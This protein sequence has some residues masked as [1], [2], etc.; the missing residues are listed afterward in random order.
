VLTP[1]ALAAFTFLWRLGTSSLFTDESASWLAAD[2]PLASVFSRVRHAEVTPPGYFVGLHFWLALTG[3]DSEWSMRLLSVLA[4]IALVGATLWLGWLLAGRYAGLLAATFVG[5][6]PLAVQYAQEV[7]GYVF[8]MLFATLA[9]AAAVEARRSARHAERW[10]AAATLASVAAIWTH[11]TCLLVIAPLAIYIWRLPALSRR[12]RGAYL[13]VCSLVLAAVAPLM[14]EQ[15]RSGHYDGVAPF[16]GLNATNIEKV[17]GT[18]FDGRYGGHP[19]VYVAGAAAIVPALVYF[20]R[21]QPLNAERRIVLAAAVLPVSAV[22]LL[23]IAAVLTGEQTY[24]V[25]VTRY[26]AVGAPFMLIALAAAIVALA[27]SRRRG[28]VAR[29]A[30]AALVVL[31]AFASVSGLLATYASSWPDLRGAFA[32]ITGHYRAGDAV[33]VAD[34]QSRGNAHYGDADYY[35]ARL[36]QSHPGAEVTAEVGAYSAPAGAGRIWVESDTGALAAV[37]TALTAGGWHQ[38]WSG[39]FAPA[40]AAALEAR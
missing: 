17:L 25:L 37:A 3:S 14:I 19:L 16:A 35:V 38:S 8:A 32:Y 36:L 21:A 9:V 13:A 28:P 10:L 29:C 5:A 23:T 34:T 7:R 22:A 11:Y 24:R 6:S 4:G 40:A 39:Q 2:G 31:V 20:A 15:W 12:A 33:I 27:R 26:T 1:L 18:P 30:A